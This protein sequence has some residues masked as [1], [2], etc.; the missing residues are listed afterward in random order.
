MK[1]IVTFVVP[2]APTESPEAGEEALA[3]AWPEQSTD[4]AFENISASPGAM[5]VEVIVSDTQAN[6]IINALLE[7][8]SGQEPGVGNG[9][10]G[11]QD[12]D[13]IE[14]LVQ[15]ELQ[16]AEPDAHDLLDRI[17]RRVERELISKVYSDCDY[18]KS[19]AAMRLGINRNTLL[20][21][22]REFGAVTE[23]ADDVPH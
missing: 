4:G 1:R 21:K 17:I 9:G 23:D 16:I 5:K 11:G 19:R 12:E 6:R 14:S 2:M 15:R 10:A 20:K 8:G 3:A 7:Q 13:A 18:V 22:L